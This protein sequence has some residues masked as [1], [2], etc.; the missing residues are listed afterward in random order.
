MSFTDATGAKNII[1]DLDWILKIVV[2]S[3]GWNHRIK[4]TTVIVVDISVVRW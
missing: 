4:E 2:A 1:G 3:D